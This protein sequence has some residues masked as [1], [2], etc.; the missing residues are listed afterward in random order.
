MSAT[1]LINFGESPLRWVRTPRTDEP[2]KP[3]QLDLLRAM[4][5]SP[6]LL[7]GRFI[8]RPD[9]YQTTVKVCPNCQSASPAGVCR[10]CGL[11][12]VG[13]TV[14]KDWAASAEFCKK[15]TEQQGKAGVQVVSSTL[16]DA[17]ASMAKALHEDP[18]F[19]ELFEQSKTLCLIQGTWHDAETGLGVPLHCTLD[20]AP[21]DDGTLNMG[22]GSL[23]ITGDASPTQWAASAFS[24]GLHIRA[25]LKNALFGAAVS[26]PRSVH[27][28]AIVERDEPYLTARRRSTPEL[29]N[30]GADTLGLLIGAYAQCLKRDIWPAFDLT[31][32]GSL[33]AWS[34]V[35]L[36]PWMTQGSPS[37]SQYFA[38]GQVG[39]TV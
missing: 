28:W 11:K 13:K 18:N 17:T 26:D 1:D 32:A 34:E 37:G 38:L 22:A 9:T 6:G 20:F 7:N 31:V 12:R 25:A 36:E 3:R 15:W 16:W 24:K 33:N 23:A 19:V 39:Q 10:A 2:S 4:T 30:N 27:V 5:L 14:E 35:Y 8:R 29:L 21:L